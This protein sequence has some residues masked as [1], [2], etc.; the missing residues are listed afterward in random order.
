MRRSERPLVKKTLNLYE[1][2]IEILKKFFPATGWQVGVRN[3]VHRA[4]RQLEER[5][6]Q[7]ISS[8]E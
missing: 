7:A 2:D 3:I 5:T 6:A 8:E 4:C 1:E